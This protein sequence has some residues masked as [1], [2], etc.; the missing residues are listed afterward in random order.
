MDKI[1][2]LILKF[3][4]MNSRV[5]PSTEELVI[6]YDHAMAFL[7]STFSLCVNYANNNVFNI[8]LGNV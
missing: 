3:H 1:K 8:L 6:N 5:D 2:V 4:A 7:Y